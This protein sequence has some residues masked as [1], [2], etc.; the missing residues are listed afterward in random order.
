MRLYYIKTNKMGSIFEKF[1]PIEI[2]DFK[3]CALWQREKWFI[4]VLWAEQ[5]DG[6]RILQCNI[7][8]DNSYIIDW[9]DDLFD[10]FEEGLQFY[11]DKFKS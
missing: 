11:K 4:E 2:V 7:R 1:T 5:N 8:N 3:A 10:S 6:K 9:W